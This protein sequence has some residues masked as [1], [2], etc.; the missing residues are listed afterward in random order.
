MK[1]LIFDL[2]NVIIDIDFDLTFRK[3][4]KLSTEYSWE[5]VRYFIKDK[6][7]WENYEKG[8]IND[9]K[10]RET[11]RKELKI[12]ASDNELDIAFCGL[13]QKIQPERIKLLQDLSKKYRLFI[14][15]NT[16][17]IHFQQ[18]EKLLFESS[19]IQHFRDIFEI[20]FLS[21]EMGKLKPEIEIYQQVL[22]E[23]NIQA[24]ETIFFDDMLVNLESAATLGIKT[25]QI[26]P[27]KFTIIDFFKNNEI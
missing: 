1:N 10:F 16:S 22:Q 23:A 3:F 14:L 19:G 26:I 27:N 6:C 9:E 15:S 25:Q 12:K 21:F 8:L 11:L 18:V 7:I 24:N 2:G 4:A 13:L 5:E 20:V 17:N